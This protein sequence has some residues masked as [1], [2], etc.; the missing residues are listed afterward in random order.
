MSGSLERGDPLPMERRIVEVMGVD[1]HPICDARKALVYIG[2]A[3]RNPGFSLRSRPRVLA[4]GPAGLR[5][6]PTWL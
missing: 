2:V 4:S 3:Q 6:P 1:R 5:M